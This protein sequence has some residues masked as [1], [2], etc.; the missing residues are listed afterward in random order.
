MARVIVIGGGLGGLTTAIAFCRKD[1]DVSVHEATPE[2]RHGR[3]SG[4]HGRTE[5]EDEQN[6]ESEAPR[7]RESKIHAE[8]RLILSR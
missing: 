8:E 4:P 7:N 3:F 5:T 6:R 1:W 2:L